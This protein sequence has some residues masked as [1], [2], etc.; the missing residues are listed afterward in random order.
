MISNLQPAMNTTVMLS[1]PIIAATA[2]RPAA[3]VVAGESA[4]LGLGRASH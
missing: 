4:R 2:R 3:L 1:V